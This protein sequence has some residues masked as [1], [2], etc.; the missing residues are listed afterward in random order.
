MI[1]DN[2]KRIIISIVLLVALVIGFVIYI[3][4]TNENYSTLD[5]ENDIVVE[6]GED[7]DNGKENS[8]QSADSTKDTDDDNDIDNKNQTTEGVVEIAVHI[9]GEVKK[10]GLIYLKEGSR[11][12]DAIE[13]AG[14]ET[15]NADLSQINLAYVLQD[16]QKI[17]VP[18]KNEKISQYITENSGNNDT[19][20]SN[21]SNSDKEDKKVNINTANQSE[22]DSLPGIGPSI[23]QKIIDYREENGNFKNIE[24]LQNVK[25]IGDAKYEEIK[26]MVTV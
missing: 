7:V 14:G 20:R 10:Q 5:L 4:N 11:V 15:K 19:E 18:N 8:M 24:E 6:S 25:G 9:T 3:F 17:Y 23:A 16:G 13:K 22:L 26:D 12:A 1:L 21:T 2:K